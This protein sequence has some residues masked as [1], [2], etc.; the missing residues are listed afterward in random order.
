MQHAQFPLGRAT[1]GTLSARS[2]A[3]LGAKGLQHTAC[4][5]SADVGFAVAPSEEMGC[6]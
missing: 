1:I 5:M 2:G 3:I 6:L 4:G